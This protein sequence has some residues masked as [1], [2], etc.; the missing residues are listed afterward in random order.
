ML[1]VIEFA[2]NNAVHAITCYTPFFVNGLT[3]PRVPLTLPLSGSGLGG[4]GMADW[5]ADVS[6][7]TVN[8]QVREFLA[9]RFNDLRHVRDTMVEIKDK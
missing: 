6:P 4:G 5:L 9:A 7:S 2:L 3:H 8:K 1:P